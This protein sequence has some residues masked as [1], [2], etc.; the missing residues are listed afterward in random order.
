[1]ARFVADLT[2][3]RASPEFR[4]IYAGQL[5]SFLG[6]Q[7]TVVAVPV[8]VYAMTRSSLA[9]GLVGA[10]EL[11]PLLIGSLAGGS[12]VDSRDRRML[13]LAMQVC[14]AFCTTALAVNAT[15]DRPRLWPLY[16]FPAMAALF[17]GVD[18]PARGATLPRL[19]GADMLP[20]AN[21]LWQILI[22]VGTVVG[23]SLA[24]LLILR[25]S[26]ATVFW[27]DVATFAIAFVAIAGLPPLPPEGGGTKAGLG[28]IAEGLRFLRGRRLLQSTFLID[29]DA[30]VFG[31]PRALFPAIAAT[32]YGGGPGTVGLLYAAIGA[33]S[34][35]GATTSGWVGTVRRQGRAVVI[36]VTV[37]G[38]AMAAFGVVRWLPLGLLLLATAGAADVI[39]AVFRNTILQS[40]VPDAMR[41]RMASVHIAVVTGGPR[42]GDV[43]A[44]VAATLIGVQAA[45]V[46]GGLACL[47]GVVAVARWFPE[48][49]RHDRIERDPSMPG[50][51][52]PPGAEPSELPPD[53]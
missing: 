10:A 33:G 40:R 46:T 17:S 37:W 1:M 26:L 20:A 42:L 51:P 35:V 2:P 22:S 7:I 44:G 25:S 41:G 43:E 21:A 31:L 4:R 29:L 53:P 32:L 23:P 49:M 9:V 28:S 34:M 13:M 50:L 12:I 52:H 11:V 15:I 5:V 24:G 48:L 36:A 16:V 8:Q 14:L 45:V 47:V 3:L 18:R 30:M 27:V 38:A 6:T 19:V 39:S